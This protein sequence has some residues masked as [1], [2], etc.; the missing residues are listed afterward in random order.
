MTEKT[1]TTTTTT[2]TRF[3]S[4]LFSALSL[5][6][7]FDRSLARRV[8]RRPRALHL[9]RRTP[10]SRRTAQVESIAG[11]VFRPR[12]RLKTQ[13]DFTRVQNTGRS[14]NGKLVRIKWCD[15]TDV[16]DVDNTRLGIKAP[17]KLLR[18]AVDRNSVKRRVRDIFRKNK[19]A[20]PSTCDMLVFCGED[21]LRAP[22]ADVKAEMLYWGTNYAPK[23][24]A[25]SAAN[26]ARKEAKVAAQSASSR[27]ESRGA[28][29]ARKGGRGGR[30]PGRGGRGGRGRGKPE[31]EDDDDDDDDDE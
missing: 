7:S 28:V 31:P 24:A 11:E 23:V 29:R 19:E 20:W 25:Q 18:R 17:K 14:F 10:S 9:T 4:F 5:A 16:P 1:T 6:R 13:A 21:A 12:E 30:G 8:A 2:T 26:R 3:S 27:G 15:T 22:Y